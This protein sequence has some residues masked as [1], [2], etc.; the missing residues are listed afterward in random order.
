MIEI[1]S[2]QMIE[3]NTKI[4]I[5]IEIDPF[6]RIKMDFLKSKVDQNLCIKIL[7]PLFKKSN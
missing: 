3:I 7:S 5:E 4:N 6:S 2:I 1:K